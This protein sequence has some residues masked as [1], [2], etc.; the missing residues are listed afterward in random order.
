VSSFGT[1][2]P[3]PNIYLNATTQAYSYPTSLYNCSAPFTLN[4]NFTCPFGIFN[5]YYRNATIIS[6]KCIDVQTS[7]TGCLFDSNSCPVN[8]G[9]V[10]FNGSMTQNSVAYQLKCCPI[11]A[12]FSNFT[13]PTSTPTQTGAGYRLSSGAAGFLILMVYFLL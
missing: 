6:F 1:C 2:N 10:A 5:Q 12:S 8:Y 7:F 13:F 3:I 9:I 4:S 11:I